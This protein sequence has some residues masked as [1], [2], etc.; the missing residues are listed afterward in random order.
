MRNSARKYKMR[1][2]DALGLWKSDRT[3][4]ASDD[5]GNRRKRARTEASEREE[6]KCKG[7]EAEANELDFDRK[8]PTKVLNPDRMHSL[9][10]LKHVLLQ[11]I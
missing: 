6:K 10:T 11:Q 1:L 4:G 9:L 7:S 2:L 8:L 5:G 3:G